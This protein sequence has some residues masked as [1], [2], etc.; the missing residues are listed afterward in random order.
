MR[1]TPSLFF[2]FPFSPL[3]PF[4]SLPLFLSVLHAVKGELGGFFVYILDAFFRV[5]RW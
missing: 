1:G 4:L 3:L 5:R 2:F